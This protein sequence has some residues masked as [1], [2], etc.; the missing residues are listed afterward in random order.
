V[1]GQL[2]TSRYRIDLVVMHPQ[3]HGRYL[4]AIE[5][6][7]ATYHSAPTARDR[8][9]LRQQQLEALGWHFHR[10][11]STD[12]FLRRADEIERVMKA[13]ERAVRRAD[14]EDD[15]EELRNEAIPVVA[16]ST[17]QATRTRGPKPL[18]PMGQPIDKYGRSQLANVIRWVESD[19]CLRT[20]DEI[21]IEV[22]RALGFMRRGPNIVAAIR[23]AIP[24]SRQ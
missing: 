4:L 19:G 14:D 17:V 6:D 12:W 9:R 3:H 23:N 5:C 11:W 8:D 16:S 10:I 2:G 21:V 1:I 22:M 20:D 7:G 24:Y 15:G 18:V 13:Y